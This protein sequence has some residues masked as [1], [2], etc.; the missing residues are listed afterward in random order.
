MGGTHKDVDTA[1]SGEQE[2]VLHEQ[3]GEGVVDMSWRIGVVD[4][5]DSLA[6]ELLDH[7]REVMC[8]PEMDLK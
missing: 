6:E 5:N 1:L 3:A 8:S 7:L 2:R 4:D